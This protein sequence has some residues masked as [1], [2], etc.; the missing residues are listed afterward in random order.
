MNVRVP[1]PEPSLDDVSKME[2]LKAYA[3][4]EIEIPS[5]LDTAVDLMLAS[6][7]Y[8]ELDCVPSYSKNGW[9][10]SG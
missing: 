5:T 1:R 2:Q 9:S 6:L 4:V 10:C 3:L 8:F 7:F